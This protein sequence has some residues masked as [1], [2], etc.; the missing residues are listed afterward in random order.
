M[1]RSFSFSI[2]GTPVATHDPFSPRAI[3][4]AGWLRSDEVI[5]ADRMEEWDSKKYS[6]ACK[7]AF[8][9]RQTEFSQKDASKFSE[10]L[11]TYLQKDVVCTGLEVNRGLNGYNYY[12]FYYR[13]SS[14]DEPENLV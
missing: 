5:W 3:Y 9:R 2:D 11:S 8:G 1:I 12:T 10:F 13:N 14:A 6:D 7:K 4:R